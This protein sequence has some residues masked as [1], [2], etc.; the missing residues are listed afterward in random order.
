MILGRLRIVSQRLAELPD[1][2]FHHG[3]AHERSGPHRVEQL[4]FGHQL[5]AVIHEMLQDRVDLR[6]ERG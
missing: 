6:P 1:D 3:I 4:L 5:T 2:A